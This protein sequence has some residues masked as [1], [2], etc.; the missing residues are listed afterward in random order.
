MNTYIYQATHNSKE[1]CF[2]IRTDKTLQ[3]L[4]NFLREK[5][6]KLVIE[7]RENCEVYPYEFCPF[8][9]TWNDDIKFLTT[10]CFTGEINQYIIPLHMWKG[11]NF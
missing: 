10:L 11:V 9:V 7:S 4:C 2:P 8:H 6:T 5:A 3:E 1:V